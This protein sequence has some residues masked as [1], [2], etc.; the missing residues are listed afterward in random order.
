MNVAVQR[1]RDYLLSE[2]CHLPRRE[3][4]RS[5]KVTSDKKKRVIIAGKFEN[6]NGL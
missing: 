6:K 4:P 5:D 1:I 2:D 3:E